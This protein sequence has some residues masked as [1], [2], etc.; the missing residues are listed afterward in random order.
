MHHIFFFD[1][2]L[3]FLGLDFVADTGKTRIEH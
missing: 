2:L 1:K 3:G